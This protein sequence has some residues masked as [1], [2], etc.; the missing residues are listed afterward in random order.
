MNDRVMVL[1]SKPKEL[2]QDK[3]CV[4]IVC[5][6]CH[7]QPLFALVPKTVRV[8]GLGEIECPYCGCLGV[9]TQ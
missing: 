9:L 6:N 2:V 1:K 3:Y 5:S 8:T 7:E 4:G